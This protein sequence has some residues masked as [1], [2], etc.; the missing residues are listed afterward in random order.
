VSS[1]SMY[2]MAKSSM[3]RQNVM[4]HVSCHQR[5]VMCVQGEYPEMPK[6]LTTVHRQGCLF[7]AGRICICLFILRHILGVH[8]IADCIAL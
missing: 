3:T 6:Y 1:T 2:L 5:P 8:M 4:A 7:G